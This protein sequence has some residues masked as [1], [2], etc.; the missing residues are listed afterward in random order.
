MARAACSPAR[1]RRLITFSA[2]TVALEPDATARPKS[3]CRASRRASPGNAEPQA[4]AF[5]RVRER[6]RRAD[7]SATSVHVEYTF[8]NKKTTRRAD[9]R[10][11]RAVVHGVAALAAA[12]RRLDARLGTRGQAN[13]QLLDRRN[14]AW[15]VLVS[16]SHFSNKVLSLGAASSICIMPDGS[17]VVVPHSRTAAAAPAVKRADRRPSD[18]RA[19]VPPVH[20]QRRQRRRHSAGLRSAR[21]LRASYRSAIACRATSSRFRT[22]STCSTAGC[23][24]R[25][26]STTRAARA[27]START[28]SSATPVRSPAATRR[29]RRRRSI[30]RRAAIAKTYGTTLNGTSYKTSAGYFMN[31]Q[32][33]KFREFSA[34]VQLPNVV[35]QPPARGERLDAR[36]RRAEPPHVDVAGRASIRKRTTAS[37]SRKRRT[38]S[39]PPALPTYFTLRL[40]LKY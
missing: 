28:T 34:I 13:A 2:G 33:W 16:A 21:R 4:G 31:N 26:C 37:R 40:N 36:V 27:L 7:C 11:P 20:V 8:W 38:S 32:F 30:G 12:Q 25:R 23:A 17:Q 39:R 18:Q 3:T 15:D 6:L 9:Q 35:N 10:Q 5:G 22:A 19:V 29:I 14:F 1:R 24:S